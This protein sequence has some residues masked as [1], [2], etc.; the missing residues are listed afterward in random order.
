MLGK[1]PVG[2]HRRPSRGSMI[3][4]DMQGEGFLAI[5]SDVDAPQETDYLHWLTRE[6]TTER[7]SVDGFIAVR[8]FRA[9]S[10]T[11]CR[12]LIVYEL[13]DTGALSGPAYLARLNSPTPW[14]QRIMPIL[15]NFVRGGGRRAIS[16][17]IGRGGF[18]AALPSP[19]GLT[20][21][22]GVVEGLA[23]QDRIAAAHLLETDREKTLI[24]T[25]EKKLRPKDKSFDSLLLVE[26]LDQKALRR[27]LLAFPALLP[28]GVSAED[29]PFYAC[30]FAQDGRR[31][32]AS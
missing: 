14:S 26:G 9:I 22:A 21:K 29:V 8:V 28:A 13:E 18:V 7:L 30:V 24:Q 6:H 20:D 1:Q 32:S 3:E 11:I 10:D 2:F 23:S 25:Q 16:K 15:R 31:W 19:Q 17:G 27:A 12:F 4:G 5:W